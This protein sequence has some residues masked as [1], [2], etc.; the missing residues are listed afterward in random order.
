MTPVTLCREEEREGEGERDQ[1]TEKQVNIN[2]NSTLF[3]FSA[4][5]YHS[6]IYR[7]TGCFQG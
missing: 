2:N 1:I 6:C 4:V 3:L 5:L 7:R